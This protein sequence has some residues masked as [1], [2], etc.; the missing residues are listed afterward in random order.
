MSRLAKA[1]AYKSH[2]DPASVLSLSQWNFALPANP[3]LLLELVAAPVNPSD[4]KVVQGTYPLLS[5]KN[6][7]GVFVGGLEG[8]FKVK[9]TTS[10]EFK[11]GDWAVPK[12][13]SFSLNLICADRRYL[14]DFNRCCVVYTHYVCGKIFGNFDT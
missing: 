14:G 13:G 11:V 3:F 12:Q 4:I 9:E 5:T 8:A 10:N 6:S 1:I 2:G 7:N